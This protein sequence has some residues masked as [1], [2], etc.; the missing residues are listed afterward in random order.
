[1]PLYTNA[2]GDVDTPVPIDPFTFVA[3]PVEH[4]PTGKVAPQSNPPVDFAVPA[5]PAHVISTSS[6][7]ANPSI[8]QAKRL[9]AAPK[10]AFPEASMPA[11]LAKIKELNTGSLAVIIEG[12][13]KELNALVKK[14]A[15]EA[16]V[17]EIGE[18]SK[19][20]GAGKVWVVK[21]EVRVSTFRTYR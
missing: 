6:A 17:R 14:N 12:V 4:I 8:D 9:T 1:M 2:C 3:A 19:E 16:K 18:K 7:P 13:Y 20:A 21:P 10:T 11:L 15:I 5:L